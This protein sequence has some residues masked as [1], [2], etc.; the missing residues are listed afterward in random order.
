AWRL[1]ADLVGTHVLGR[2]ACPVDGGEGPEAVRSD[3]FSVGIAAGA[4]ARG[5]GLTAH[6]A[7]DFSARIPAVG[8]LA[9]ALLGLATVALHT[10]M[11]PGHTQLLSGERGLL[12]TRS[13][14]YAAVAALALVVLVGWSWAWIQ[15]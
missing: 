4:L 6:S 2:G 15:G 13:P 8:I 9:A 5:A 14:I 11:Q 10:R 7:L 12:L 3:R 1:V